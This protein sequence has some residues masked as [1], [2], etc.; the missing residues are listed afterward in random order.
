MLKKEVR[1]ALQKV[2]W[3]GTVWSLKKI[4]GDPVLNVGLY[5]NRD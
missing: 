5:C 2:F 1:M 4:Q 3:R